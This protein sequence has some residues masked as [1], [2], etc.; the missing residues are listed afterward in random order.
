MYICRTPQLPTGLRPYPFPA[1]MPLPTSWTLHLP[2]LHLA[3]GTLDSNVFG[4]GH[5]AANYHLLKTA[6]PFICL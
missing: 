5:W 1:A 3:L 6:I 2:Y 4:V